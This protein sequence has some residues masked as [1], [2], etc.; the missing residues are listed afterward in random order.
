M[1][2]VCRQIYKANLKLLYKESLCVFILSL[3]FFSQFSKQYVRRSA[4]IIDQLYQ[5]SPLR[6]ET[7][8]F[9]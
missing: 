8:K 5:A 7:K 3:L 1:S 9:H 2:R 6:K 4:H